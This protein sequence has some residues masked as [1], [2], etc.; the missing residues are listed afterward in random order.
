MKK[1][2]GHRVPPLGM[3]MRV[4]RNGLPEQVSQEP[5]QEEWKEYVSRLVRRAVIQEGLSE[6]KTPEEIKK[7]WQEQA[8]RVQETVAHL[9]SELFVLNEDALNSAQYITRELRKRYPGFPS[10]RLSIGGSAIHGGMALRRLLHTMQETDL[11][12]G[13]IYSSQDAAGIDT[14]LLREMSEFIGK[15]LKEGYEM[16]KWKNITKYHLQK[17]QSIEAHHRSAFGSVD[18]AVTELLSIRSVQDMK[19]KNLQLLLW[20]LVEGNGD[21][22][23]DQLEM[24]LQALSRIHK[25][26]QEKWKN[27]VGWFV[28]MWTEF[29][30]LKDKHVNFPGAR[31][32]D[33]SLS[34][35]IDSWSQ[36]V[37]KQPFVKMLLS[38][39]TEK[40]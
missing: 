39:G 20:P 25:Q 16:G 13:L 12:I 21:I 36:E 6:G 34:L 31:S 40:E 3:Y 23:E 18:E 2:S 15:S 35:V 29:H 26:D 32:Q 19:K 24:I 11:D 8:G 38:T 7:R 9:T 27:L 30:R 5:N 22:G 4:R 33:A 14:D 1:S 17:A 28:K 37:M 10:L